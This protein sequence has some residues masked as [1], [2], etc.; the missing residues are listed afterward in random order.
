V[1]AAFFSQWAGTKQI[2]FIKFI[3]KEIWCKICK[4]SEIIKFDKLNGGRDR[5]FL[6]GA[7]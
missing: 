4:I 6:T 1:N 5:R 3:K 7:E 2:Q